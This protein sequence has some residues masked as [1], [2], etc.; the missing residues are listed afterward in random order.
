MDE[1]E[2][3]LERLNSYIRR[4]YWGRERASGS[5]FARNSFVQWIAGIGGREVG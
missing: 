4:G 5:D 1:R 3:G 2:V